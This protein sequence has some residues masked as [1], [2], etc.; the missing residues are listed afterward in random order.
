MY[1]CVFMIA[2]I[3]GRTVI[4]GDLRH[5]DDFMSMDYIEGTAELLLLH[6][7]KFIHWL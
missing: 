6:G 4:S 1:S 7:F 5:S 3:E 2:V